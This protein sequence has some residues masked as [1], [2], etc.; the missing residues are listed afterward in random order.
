M[1]HL[2]PGAVCPGHVSGLDDKGVDVDTLY[3]LHIVIGLE[4]FFLVITVVK[5]SYDSWRYVCHGELP[6]IA[7]KIM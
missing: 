7:A 3:L 4:I 2:L 6:W 1:L 5:F